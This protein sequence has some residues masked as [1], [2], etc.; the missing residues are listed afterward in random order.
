VLAEEAFVADAASD[1]MTLA[2]VQYGRK[3]FQ[4]LYAW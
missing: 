2:F 3:R 4:L 1:Q